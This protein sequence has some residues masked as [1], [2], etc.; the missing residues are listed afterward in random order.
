MHALLR[1]NQLRMY[2]NTSSIDDDS[3]LFLLLMCDDLS[4]LMTYLLSGILQLKDY[5]ELQTYKDLGL[6]HL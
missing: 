2:L 4:T 5:P 1:A 6:S 3:P